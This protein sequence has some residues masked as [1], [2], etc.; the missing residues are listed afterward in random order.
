LVRLERVVEAIL[1]NAVAEGQELKHARVRDAK[2][3]AV[4]SLGGSAL[5]AN[6]L[7]AELGER[8][9]SL[10]E[11]ALV[12]A[13]IDAVP[14]LREAVSTEIRRAIEEGRALV[15]SE[16]LC[17]Q[18]GLDAF[19][20]TAT[21]LGERAKR[22]EA[23]TPREQFVLDSVERFRTDTAFRIGTEEALWKGQHRR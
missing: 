5:D 11:A 17:S 19:I 2:V 10:G 6:F 3:A 7:A 1:S 18:A 20:T 13:R 8:S 4:L 12:L 15:A 21:A 9:R 22:G 14:G 16:A 23:L